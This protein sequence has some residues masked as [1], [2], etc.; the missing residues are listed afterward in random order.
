MEIYPGRARCSLC[1]KY[2]KFIG[3]KKLGNTGIDEPYYECK[4]HKKMS[5]LDVEFIEESEDIDY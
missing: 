3:C 2:V 5:F 4:K 1:G